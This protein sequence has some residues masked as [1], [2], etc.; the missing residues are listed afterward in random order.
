MREEERKGASRDRCGK[1]CKGS[2]RSERDKRLQVGG[3][4]EGKS[5]EVGEEDDT[6]TKAQYGQG[7]KEEPLI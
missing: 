4:E 1:K 5:V 2:R 3:Q 7:E 6:G